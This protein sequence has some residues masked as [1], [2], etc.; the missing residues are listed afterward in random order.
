MFNRE[1]NYLVLKNRDVN[2]VLTELEREILFKLVGKIKDHRELLGKPALK[3][4]V[5][6]SDWPEYEPTWK[7][8]EDRVTAKCTCCARGGEY[9]GFGSDGPL[10]FH[11]DLPNGCSCHD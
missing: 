8:I 10:L 2:F 11:C 5:V 7:A 6:E 9:N 3:C 4:V 1:S